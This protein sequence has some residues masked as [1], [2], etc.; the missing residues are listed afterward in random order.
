MQTLP[1]E[2]IVQISESLTF[3]ELQNLASTCKD[4]YNIF[5]KDIKD[6]QAIE[7]VLKSYYIRVIVSKY[8]IIDYKFYIYNTKR[9]LKMCYDRR[10]LNTKLLHRYL[11][12]IEPSVVM[13]RYE[14][15]RELHKEVLVETKKI[16]FQL[17]LDIVIS[18]YLQNLNELNEEEKN[19]TNDDDELFD[20]NEYYERTEQ[21]YQ[22]YY[23]K[24]IEK[25]LK[26]LKDTIKHPKVMFRLL[27]NANSK[28][29]LHW[30]SSKS[31]V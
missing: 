27:L 9:A 25:A 5:Y 31:Y 1:K 2:L 3:E 8:W 12:N 18:S 29:T 24:G 16:D 19:N 4:Y 21:I 20:M 28:S 22:C 23:N 17:F 26:I 7:K 13:K 14:Y 30:T 6:L 11:P 15:D 10:D